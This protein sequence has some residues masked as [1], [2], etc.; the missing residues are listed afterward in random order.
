MNEKP[1]YEELERRIQELESIE[2]KL[3]HLKKE[4]RESE[5]LFKRL[6]EKAPLGYQSLD[7]NGHFIVV[8]QAWLDILGYTQEEVI[9]KSFADFLPSEWRDHFKENFPRFKAIGE[10]LGVEFEMVK[11]NGDPILVSFTGK[12]SR[13]EKGNFQQTHCIFN[14]ITEHRRQE[15]ELKKIEWML[16]GKPSAKY[17]EALGYGD[18]TAL[19]RGGLIARSIDKATL[20]GISSEYLD[21]L[22]TSSAIYEKNGDYAFGIFCSGWCRLLDSAS[23][24]LCRT[25]D[26]EVALASGKWLCHESCWTDCSK[27]AIESQSPVA[28]KCKGG[29]NIYA[30]PIFSAGEVIGAINFGYGDPPKDPAKLRSLADFYGLDPE[31]LAHEANAY[32]SRPSFII[33]LAKQ[34]LLSSA[35]L[36]GVMVERKRAE[37]ELRERESLFRTLVNTIPDLIWLKDADGAY[38][39]CNIRFERFFGAGE[40]DIVGKTDYD[41]IDK[42][43]ADFFRENDR[44]AMAVGGP[45]SNEEQITF[46]D[47]GHM[48]FLETIK[49]PMFDTDGKLIGVLGIGREITDRKRA[50]EALEKRLVALTQPLDTPEGISFE[51]LFVLADIQRLQD[52]FALATGVASIITRPDGTPLTK[53]S[54]FCR[55]CSDLIRKTEMGLANCFKSDAAWGRPRHDGP[56]IQPCL[57][58]GLWDAGAAITVGGHHVANWLIGQV[59]DADQTEE[60]MRAYARKIGADE[61][62]VAEAFHEV[63][64]MSH[65]Q[66]EHVARVLFTL[67][68][69]LSAA[70]YQN[71]QQARFITERKRA[72]EALLESE[73][74]IGSIFRSAPIGIGSV[75]NRVLTKVNNRLCEMTGYN[76][77]DLIGRSAR[78]LYLNDEDFEFVGREKY[79][80]IADHGTGTVETRWQKHDGAVMDVLLSST[81]VNLQDLSKG[82]TFTALDITERKRAEEELRESEERFKALH[83]ASFGGIAI[84]DKGVIL[85]CNQGLS[86]ISGFGLDEL[87]GMD[88]LLLIAEQSREAVMAN[89][90]SGFEEPYEAL[91]VRKNGE[92][93]SLRLEARNIPYKGKMVRVVEFRDITEAKQ[94]EEALRESE[95]TFRKLFEDSAD[96][97]LLI[98]KT[99]VFV[100]CNQAAL[101]LLK[102]TR[103]QFLFKPPVDISPEYQP[104][105]QNSREKALKMIEIAYEK[106]LHRFDWTCINS[107]GNEFIVEVSL[108]PIKVKGELMLYSSWHNIT[109]RKRAE[110]ALIRQQRSIHLNNRIA[111]VFL[112]SSQDEVFADVL[113]VIRTALDSRFGY[114]GYIDEAGDLVCPTLT[115]DIWDQCQVTEKSIVFHR[116]YWSGL[117]GRSLLEKQTL[118]ANENLQVPGGHMALKNALATPIVY[119]DNLIG[120]LVLANKAGGYDKDDRD[121]LESAAAQTA[122]ILF[123]IREE[124]RQKI[125]HEKLEDQLR[126]AQKMEAVGR[127]AGGVAHDFNNMLGVII[128]LADILLI[129]M[130]PDSPFH[131]HITEIRKAGERSADLTRK[132]L[133][134]ARKQTVAPK[135]LDFNDTIES[136]LKLLHRL[137][138]EDIDLL[139]KP[140]Q[141]LW[142]VKM[143]PS[144]I[145]QILANL[146]VNARDAIVG[147]GKVTIETDKAFFDEEYCDRNAD[148]VPGDYVL[149]AVSDNGCGMDTETISHLFE[150]FFTTKASGMGMGLPISQTILENHDGRIWAE[151]EP[152]QGTVFHVALPLAEIPAAEDPEPEPPTAIGTTR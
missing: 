58:G 147:V 100:E 19:N 152:G 9:G 69:Q 146:C 65:E 108:M 87:I 97:I 103:E 25:E 56:T 96:A 144:Q 66:F 92:E 24:N 74:Q 132:L 16:T 49:T 149:L 115:R 122:P 54:N 4:V 105:G 148:F 93:Y 38:L 117:W 50:E 7:E 82:V 17:S 6:Y 1:T 10:I 118:I 129:K 126:Q 142:P 44:K 135:V 37:N 94:A 63:P 106:N 34:R 137:I 35:G 125:A 119:N 83:N 18:L 140:G 84:H 51:D 138:G 109:E 41:F 68:N 111:T 145:D 150:P 102:M 12:I 81:P 36:I 11:K 13:D 53:P 27:L 127:L 62:A 47:D 101:T 89:I 43:L 131:A 77:T 151:S 33:E 67:A 22:E 31:K 72:E 139:W 45:I 60:K 28:I 99:G 86:E 73:N 42:E 136:M 130:A 46:A 14:D 91:G 110:E 61:T 64:A 107:E 15:E 98:D 55:L 76:E 133:A 112:T 79:A 30:V 104:D 116:A 85:E 29:I 78:M 114:F 71:V 59:R 128:G 121:L 113:D 5:S 20:R 95:L 23:R 88:G 70:A 57:S 8:N 39:S 90:R 3:K 141:G 52:E 40:A 21:L 2:S 134:F 32:A 80:Q 26:N 75:V 120:Q 48:A 123:A 124:A 143:D